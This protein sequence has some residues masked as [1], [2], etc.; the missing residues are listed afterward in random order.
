MNEQSNILINFNTPFPVDPNCA[1]KITFPTDMNDV[2]LISTVTGADLFSSTSGLTAVS[3]Y[4]EFSGC[5]GSSTGY[6]TGASGLVNIFYAL[7][8]GYV[9]TSGTF[10]I[11]LYS[12]VGSTKYDILT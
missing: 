3:D 2:S 9:Q 7:N 8:K 5:T 6:T 10:S 4:I 11:Y 1:M 12:V